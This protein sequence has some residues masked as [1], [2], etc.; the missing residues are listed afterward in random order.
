MAPEPVRLPAAMASPA[1]GCTVN[2]GWY[3]LL[4]RLH[5]R[6]SAVTDDFT[7][8]QIKEKFGV[9]RCYLNYGDSVDD[10]TWSLCELLVDA[11][12]DESSTVCEF[13]GDRGETRYD[14]SWV[15]TTCGDC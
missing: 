10:F 1:V 6:L 5:R 7:Y 4:V 2:A 14:L 13:C 12:T 15:K 9:L 8:A 11:T 3:P